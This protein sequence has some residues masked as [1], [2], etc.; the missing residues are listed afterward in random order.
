MMTQRIARC[1]ST[2]RCQILVNQADILHMDMSSF[3]K[4][5]DVRF[6]FAAKLAHSNPE[7]KELVNTATSRAP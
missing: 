7:K 1:S 4:K 3:M 2:F 6:A 5:T